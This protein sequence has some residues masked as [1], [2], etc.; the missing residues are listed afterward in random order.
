MPRYE[1]VAIKHIKAKFFDDERLQPYLPDEKDW[2]ML[3]RQW[4]LNVLN[5][6][7]GAEF[8][9]WVKARLEERNER[10]R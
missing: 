7:L 8:G 9:D 10:R 2:Y 4:I 3:P 1:N 6:V 5:T